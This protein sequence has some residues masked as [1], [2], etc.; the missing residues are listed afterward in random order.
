MDRDKLPFCF[1]RIFFRGPCDFLARRV[2]FQ[3][4]KGCV[5]L[6]GAS[7]LIRGGPGRRLPFCFLFPYDLQMVGVF[8]SRGPWSVFSAEGAGNPI[9]EVRE[10]LFA[11]RVVGVAIRRLSFLVI[12]YSPGEAIK[13]VRYRFAIALPFARP[14]RVFRLPILMRAARLS[15]AVPVFGVDNGNELTIH[16]MEG[17]FS[18][19]S[20]LLQ[21]ACGNQGTTRVRGNVPRVVG[22]S[23]GFVLAGFLKGTVPCNFFRVLYPSAFFIWMSDVL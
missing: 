21:V 22:L 19:L 11:I 5:V 12:F 23:L 8:A 14:T 20:A 3:A 1:F 17:K 6:S 7:F 15:F 13:V 10:G 18:I 16:M 2:I 4:L 9:K